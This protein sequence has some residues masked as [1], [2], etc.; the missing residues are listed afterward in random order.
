MKLLPLT[1]LGAN[2]RGRVLRFGLLLPGISTGQG[3]RMSLTILHEK[4]Q[5][6][7]EVPPVVVPMRHAP[8]ARHGDYW[9]AEVDL[10][11]PTSRPGP[12]WG[13]PGRYVYSYRLR[14]PWGEEIGEIS[15]P[16]ATEFGIG[17]LSAVTVGERP[18][19]WSDAEAR[20]RVPP[21]DRLVMYELQVHEF[22]GDLARVVDRMDYLADLG[23]TCLQLMP[24]S[25]V[26]RHS[27]WGYVP[28]GHFGVDE[29]FGGARDLQRLVDVAHQRGIAVVLDAVYGHTSLMFPYA[30]LYGRLPDL[31]NPFV[32]DFGANMFSDGV[33]SPNYHCDL[34]RDF[35][36]TLNRHHLDA[37][38][39]DGF[40]YDCVPNY[41]DGPTGDGFA[42]LCYRTY[43]M[44][45]ATGGAGY[46][47]RFFDADRI[48]LIQVAEWLD[49]PLDAL[50]QTYS[51]S[52]WQDGTREAAV[53]LARGSHEALAT[54]GARLG[55]HDPEF[56]R[57][58]VNDDDILDKLPL[59]YLENH[60]HSRLLAELGPTRNPDIGGDPLFIE[61]DRA[62]CYRLQ[63]YLI[64]LLTARGIPLLWQGQEFGESYTLRPGGL[65]K[66]GVARPVR[67]EY[68][69]DAA[70]RP[71]VR[72]VR[73][74]LALRQRL[75]QLRGDHHVVHD[76]EEHRA[77]QVMVIE[78]R[79]ERALS[80][81]ALNFS[82]SDQVVYLRPPIGGDFR[83]ELH[84]DDVLRDMVAGES[85]KIT[86]PSNYGRIWTAIGD[87]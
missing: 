83:E 9:S 82:D 60:D 29:R 69:S 20:W 17:T 75:D 5:F 28:Q 31:A 40:R 55:L 73:R 19:R 34:T 1:R 37:F 71:L 76:D 22:A 39:V 6:R 65:G 52:A 64:A 13:R 7:Q 81:V 12:A 84:G 47:R 80:L 24:L 35:Y 68:F 8:D 15:D 49:R 4:D 66:V 25:N 72:L 61:G 74:L 21:L 26:Q 44:V 30:H 33:A 48:G 62:F 57:R 36:Y 43:Q 41:W 54:F 87:R 53:A 63:P 23:V 58:V 56:P 67:W 79:S 50:G 11:Q 27:D 70:G 45:K 51:T 16:F 3:Y 85:T 78:R 77:K 14:T 86:V 18:Y 42:N 32:G 59:Q 10:D 2:Q 46:Y 38:H